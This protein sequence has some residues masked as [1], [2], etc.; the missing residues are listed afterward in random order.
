MKKLAIKERVMLVLLV[1]LIAIVGAKSMIFDPVQTDDE[2]MQLVL[3]KMETVVGEKHTHALYKYKIITT[4][5]I[6]VKH[7]DE[8]LFRGHYRKYFLSI[9]PI[10]DVYFVTEIVIE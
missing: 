1:I 5:M 8:N 4:R 9:F 3:E 6:D 10:G 7:E 2:M